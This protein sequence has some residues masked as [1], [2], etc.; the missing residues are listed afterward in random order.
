ML[1]PKN[2]ESAY[3][4]NDVVP[5]RPFGPHPPT[6]SSSTPVSEYDCDGLIFSTPTG[7]LPITSLQAAPLLVAVSAPLP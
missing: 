4:L 7:Q 1:Q 2:G 3:G 6:D 5:K